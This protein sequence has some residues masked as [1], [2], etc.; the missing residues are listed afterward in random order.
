M[1]AQIR[2]KFYE[3]CLNTKD[4][5]LH[6]RN[7]IVLH[8]EFCEIER[9]TIKCHK[10][11]FLSIQASHIIPSGRDETFSFPIVIVFLFYDV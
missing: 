5:P 7:N 2:N 4:P 8:S 6:V 9:S 11:S 3:M 1:F 10:S